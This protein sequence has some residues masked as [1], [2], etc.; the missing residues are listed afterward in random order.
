LSDTQRRWP[1][2]L[3]G[4]MNGTNNGPIAQTGEGGVDSRQGVKE[5][6][7]LTEKEKVAEANKIPWTLKRV[8]E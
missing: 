6:I 3:V 4:I 1:I 8:P 7:T 2:N 5:R